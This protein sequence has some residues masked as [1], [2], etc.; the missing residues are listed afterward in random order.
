MHQQRPDLEEIFFF[1]SIQQLDGKVIELNGQEDKN[2]ERSANDGGKTCEISD[3]A[4]LFSMVYLN[5]TF[6][7]VAVSVLYWNNG[8]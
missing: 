7:I 4:G 5:K 3:S 6:V 1:V 8:L 2:V